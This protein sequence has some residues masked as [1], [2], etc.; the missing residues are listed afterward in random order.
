MQSSLI[1]VQ[2][3]PHT[4]FNKK[5]R[6]YSWRTVGTYGQG[7]RGQKNGRETHQAEA[8][9]IRRIAELRDKMLAQKKL[10][11]PARQRQVGEARGMSSIRTT[12]ERNEE[13]PQ[14]GT[15]THGE[16]RTGKYQEEQRNEKEAGEARDEEADR[17]KQGENDPTTVAGR[18]ETSTRHQNDTIKSEE[19]D[20]TSNRAVENKGETIAAKV[21]QMTEEGDRGGV[22]T[23]EHH[24]GNEVT[25]HSQK[26][27]LSHEGGDAGGRGGNNEENAK[28]KGQR[29]SNTWGKQKVQNKAATDIDK[30]TRK[31]KAEKDTEKTA[32][33]AA[34][35][36]A[37]RTY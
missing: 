6:K 36:H 26:E 35:S 33:A 8:E 21:E 19:S 27:K 17:H 31:V 13:S 15:G 2:S 5:D 1:Q 14:E 11:V 32:E 30:G 18:E 28:S 10:D 3:S 24:K 7:R 9:E 12:C 16:D 25:E 22:N 37:R 29:M 23:Q 20:G 4:K 34:R